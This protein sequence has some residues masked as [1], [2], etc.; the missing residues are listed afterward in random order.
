MVTICY[1][2]KYSRRRNSMD[3]KQYN[4]SFT[5]TQKDYF[6][7]VNLLND[8]K[9]ERI[10][11]YLGETNS[12]NYNL[13]V[14]KYKTLRVK[15]MASTHRLKEYFVEHNEEFNNYFVFQIS[16][17]FFHNY[18]MEEGEYLLQ[19]T[20]YKKLNAEFLAKYKQ[21]FN[22]VLTR[23]EEQY[24]KLNTVAEKTAKEYEEKFGEPLRGSELNTNEANTLKAKYNKEFVQAEAIYKK[25]HFMKKEV[26]LIDSVLNKQTEYAK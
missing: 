16:L 24:N 4:E 3:I 10:K 7:L 20:D 23:K 6:E 14:E 21:D 15:I 13:M 2:K 8:M 11:E 9:V 1:N 22:G 5:Q 12:T 26:N 19:M 17:S 18:S 25:V